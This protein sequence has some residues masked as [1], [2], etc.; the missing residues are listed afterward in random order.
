MLCWVVV[1][2]WASRAAGEMRVVNS[3]GPVVT[4]RE[5]EA[6]NLSCTTDQAWFFCLWRHPAGGKECAVQEAGGYSSVCTGL[7]RL[8]LWGGTQV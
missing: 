7:D 5:G 8:T 2:V 6:A 3:S 1:L 4:V